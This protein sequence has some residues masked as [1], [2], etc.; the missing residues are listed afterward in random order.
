MAKITD[1]LD[2]TLAVDCGFDILYCMDWSHRVE[3]WSG[4]ESRFESNN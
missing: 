4:A 1:R 3:I 2:M